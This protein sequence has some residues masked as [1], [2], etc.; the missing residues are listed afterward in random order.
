MKCALVGNQNSGKTTL[1]NLLTGSNQKIGNWA[2]VTIER[3]EGI[4]KGTDITLVD[5]PGIY[6]LS[7]YT[8]E[9]E[10]SR[11]FVKDEKPD[12]II[13]II[14]ATSIERSLYLT[15]QLLELD[16]KVIIALNMEDILEKKGV[17]IDIVK[18]SKL[19]NTTIVSISALK[20][21]GIE[22]LID[23]IKENDVL[24]N[25]HNKI[26]ESL[27]EQDIEKIIEHHKDH[28]LSRFDAV[29]IFERDRL[30]KVL[31]DDEIEKI[32]K[33]QEDK[34][35][36][37]SEEL[38]ASKRYE[39]IEKI[40]DQSITFE[41][42]E[43]NI[44]DKIDKIV[45]NKWLALPIFALI[46]ALVYFF[47]VGVI[48]G[49]T[50]SFIDAL[51]NGSE[52]IELM[53][54]EVPF[55]IKGLGPLLGD[56]I[57]ESGG[58]TWAASLV[59]DGVI[60]GVGAVVSFLPQLIILFFFLSILETSGYM[61]RI[62][63]FLDRIFKRFGLSGKSLIPFIIGAGC[64]VPAIMA[65]RTVEDEKEKKMTIILTPFIPC[66]SKLPIIAL[67]ASFFFSSYA[68]LVT[69]SLY[70]FAIAII[71]LSALVM[72]KFIFKGEGTSF[73]SELPSYH[74]PSPRYVF[75]DVYDR[76]F[77]FVKRAGTTIFLCSI[78]IWFLA[79]FSLDF[80]YIEGDALSIS[81][82]YLALIG[83]IFGWIFYPMLGM[84]YSWAMTVTAI[85]GLVA[86]EQIVSSMAILSGL[87][88]GSEVFL[89][90]L[91]SFLKGYE[92]YAFMVFNLFSAPCIGAIS[93]MKSE[94]NNR[95]SLLKAILFQ[96][97]L[98]WVLGSLIGTLGWLFTL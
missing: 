48:G 20:K 93:A 43:E 26:F 18:L 83:N 52:T 71:I 60:N 94:L 46:M 65:S 41:K 76:S 16:S 69:F 3:K 22:N 62:A 34:Y 58:H 97:G 44:T 38:I 55:V 1:F 85:Q 23:H 77:A 59:Q 21:T 10:V 81:D 73:I 29:K 57:L 28:N 70:V 90:P 61:A 54:N 91:F 63:F 14:D 89:S 5:L 51:F 64:S 95:K 7:P 13:N 30:Y 92:A 67:F 72:K 75:R 32:I 88:E 37:D 27:I 25:E 2:G 68:W 6:S 15:T 9:E 96:T 86:K 39:Y 49:L 42:R 53:G 66:A 56:L 84:N 36:T 8:S 12:L 50:T 45:L 80:R 24:P 78:V 31:I 87:T 82:S 17:K 35:Q 33:S 11:K 74:I 19:L 4:I 79:S 40:R 47:S 98:A